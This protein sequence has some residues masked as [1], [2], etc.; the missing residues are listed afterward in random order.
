MPDVPP[1]PESQQPERPEAPLV[2]I[3]VSADD[4]ARRNRRIKLSILAAALA[5]LGTTAWLYKR[6]VDPLH[7][8][9]SYD[10]GVRLHKIARYDQAVLSFDRAV[11]LKPDMVDGYLM[12]GRSYVGLAK[13]DEA[14]ADFTR[15]IN[16]RPADTAALV[17]RGLAYL[18][19][20]DFQNALSDANRAIEIDAN[21]AR[22]HN[23]RG[24]ITRTMGDPKKSLSDFNRAVELAPNEDNYYQRGATYQMLGEH[25]LAITDFDQVIAFKPDEAPGYFARAES[26]RAV[27]DVQGAQADHLQGRIIDGR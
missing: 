3:P 23:L 1:N 12:R 11:K 15:V 4:V 14:I 25:R 8:Q 26:R 9:E 10:A 22:A 17:E 19:T 20:K 16:M 7:A 6:S 18:E 21:L 24:L 27:G 13:T 5:V 2:L